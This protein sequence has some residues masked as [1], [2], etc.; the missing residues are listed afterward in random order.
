MTDTNKPSTSIRYNIFLLLCLSVSYYT[1][2]HRLSDVL[3]ANN[4][5]PACKVTVTVIAMLSTVISL[6][7]LKIKNEKQI[8]IMRVVNTV[9]TIPMAVYW[10]CVD[11]IQRK[12]YS[13]FTRDE[14]LFLDF[15]NI[16]ILFLVVYC[17]FSVII[18]LRNKIKKQNN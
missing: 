11:N 17:V 15:A 16:A 3:K 14:I 1:V 12:Y 10:Y 13:I 18:W 8:K 6:I 4:L 9:N 2:S 5:M 7:A